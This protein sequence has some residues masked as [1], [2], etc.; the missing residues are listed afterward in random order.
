MFYSMFSPRFLDGD[1]S[2]YDYLFLMEPDARPIRPHWIDGMR[3]VRF[4]VQIL[5]LTMGDLLPT[6]P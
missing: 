5:S 4:A 3:C 1:V 6:Q 2:R